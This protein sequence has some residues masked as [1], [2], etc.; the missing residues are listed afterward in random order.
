MTRHQRAMANGWI[1]D[2]LVQP[3]SADQDRAIADVHGDRAW[4]V[5]ADGA[6]GT[7]YGREAAERA[8]AAPEGE[9]HA[10]LTAL[11]R[12]GALAGGQAAVV[13]AQV[14][15]GD[16]LSVRGASVGDT[17]AIGRAGSALIELTRSQRRKPLLG[18][19]DATIVA[20][21]DSGLALDWLLL[22]SDGLTTH[23]AQERIV[24][25]IDHSAPDLPRALIDLARL[26]S[27]ALADD[28]SAILIRRA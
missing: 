20:F 25:V 27:G 28:L 2:V 7:S 11:D 17:I 10:V 26:P 6:G 21:E 23:A 18:A 12:P 19:G 22:A 14:A 15:L 5:L 13:I 24:S 4:L 8:I 3:S 9:P 16:R 1:I